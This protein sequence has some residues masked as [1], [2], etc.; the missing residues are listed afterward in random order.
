M[1]LNQLQSITKSYFDYHELSRALNISPASARVAAGRYVRQGLLIR[2]RRNMY[3]L[4]KTW[5]NAG[6]EEKFIIANLGQSPSYISL[7]CA[8]GYYG[9]T[10]Q[11]QR[12]YLE[13]MT[14]HRSREI[15]VEQT[16]FKYRKISRSLYFGFEKIN[17]FF[18]ASPEK[19]L[20]DSIYL[21]SLGRYSLDWPALELHGFDQSRLKDTAE[22]FPPE[23]AKLLRKHGYIQ[24]TRNI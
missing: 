13:S 5:E 3:V 15:K 16:V 18:I 10:T 22:R 20:L 24:T 19:A 21:V 12:D 9:L 23:T 2:V 6:L 4:K 1:K 7:T 11:V 14:M 8:L 17:G